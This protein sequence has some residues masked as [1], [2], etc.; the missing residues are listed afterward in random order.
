MKWSKAQPLPVP[1]ETRWILPVKTVNTAGDLKT[2]LFLPS[3]SSKVKM[4][5]IQFMST[6]PVLDQ[7]TISIYI[8]EKE[9]AAAA[10]AD[11]ND[12]RPEFLQYSD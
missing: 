6:P 9:K 4:I 5:P 8:K 2:N 3:I 12:R 11:L 7:K 10:A 1:S